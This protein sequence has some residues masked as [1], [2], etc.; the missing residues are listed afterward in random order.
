LQLDE[1]RSRHIN[2]EG[3]E[4]AGSKNIGFI[5]SLIGLVVRQKNE[6]KTIYHNRIATL[7]KDPNIAVMFPN[8]STSTV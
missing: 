5:P 7:I 4:G 6:V 3:R 8:S 1:C 2:L